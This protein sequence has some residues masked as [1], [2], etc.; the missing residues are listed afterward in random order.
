MAIPLG[1]AFI[2]L[3]AR[4]AGLEEDLAEG[5]RKTT[6]WAKDVGD[7][8]LKYTT[9]AIL[10]GVTL[11]TTAIA[12]IGV[13]A[14]DMAGDLNSATK[15][16]QASLGAINSDADLLKRTIKDVYANNFGDSVEDVGAVVTS[17]FQN[18]NRLGNM[19]DAELKR[20][21]EQA[22]ALRDAFGEDVNKTTSAA[23]TLMREFGLTSDQAFTFIQAGMQNGLNASGD[24]LDSIGEYSNQ[25]KEGGASAEQFFSF[26]NSGLRGGML[27]T[28]KAAD[29]FKEFRL[30]IQD[31][32]DSTANALAAIGLSVT[33]ITNGLNDGSLTVLD[34]FN[35]VQKG[36]GETENQTDG[37][38]AGVALLG[39]QFEDLG[40]D[41]VNALRPMA[42]SMEDIANMTSNLGVQ[43]DSLGSFVEGMKRRFVLGF[44]PLADILLLLVNKSLPALETGFQMVMKPI[45]SFS[46][47]LAFV[48]ED[49]DTWNDMLMEFPEAIRP[50][51]VALGELINWLVH[52]EFS[53]DS[54]MDAMY[55][56]N[57]AMMDVLNVLWDVVDGVRAFGKQVKEFV[58]KYATPL[59]GALLAIGLALGVLVAFSAGVAVVTSV[60]GA[61]GAAFAL[62][63]SPIGLLLI[64]VAALGAAWYSN[65][66]GI[67]EMTFGVFEAIRQ[68]WGAFGALLE[69]DAEAFLGGLRGAWETGWTAVATFVGNLWGMVSPYLG[70]FYASAYGWFTNT[71]WAGLGQS[72]VDKISTIIGTLWSIVEPYLTQYY[73]DFVTWFTTQDWKQIGHEAVVSLLT[74]FGDLVALVAPYLS[75]FFTTVQTTLENLDWAS[76]GSSIMTGIIY[77]IGAIVGLAV[78]INEAMLTLFEGIVDWASQ[79]DWQAI[80]LYI[81]ENILKPLAG[82]QEAITNG[83][84]DMVSGAAGAA[85]DLLSGGTGFGG[86]SEGSGDGQG[87]SGS[88][89]N[90]ESDMFAQASDTS[91][92]V[93][94]LQNAT[95]GA[96]SVDNST[97]IGQVIVQ[98]PAGATRPQDY[99]QAT[100]DNLRR[101]VKARGR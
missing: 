49:G 32:S 73:N 54:I 60:L 18:M 93:P 33:D 58:T 84:S 53:I 86:G 77:A 62:I 14:F 56:W 24:F 17:V 48:A 50:I 72:V 87:A 44:T 38:N 20:A 21:T 64:A 39:S 75:T 90:G 35:L 12:G 1:S 5:K 2:A 7:S 92:F 22:I 91:G 79:Q 98:P 46:D 28:D 47:Y 10:G 11:A 13:A 70:Q 95:A 83:L 15:K 80:G 94:A 9:G 100:Q 36:I 69:G 30:R 8:V 65:F 42:L 89:G 25:F 85:Q 26:M 61:L 3:G 66:A 19:T 27:G 4:L 34:A 59:K 57:P 16:A 51:I 37:F 76:I 41:A 68:A 23:N 99:G 29:V 6:N 52:G 31:G 96:S 101:V 43:Y 63:L 78:L 45:Q 88:W 82:I 81:L 71:D 74:A 40:E 55:Y 67:Q 97:S